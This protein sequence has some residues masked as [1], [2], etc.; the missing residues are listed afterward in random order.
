MT[1]IIIISSS[2]SLNVSLK[3][4]SMIQ[5]IFQLFCTSKILKETFYRVSKYETK[6]EVGAAADVLG[7]KTVVSEFD[8]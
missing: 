7:C 3:T 5:V 1:I 4:D 8:L 2:S 6:K